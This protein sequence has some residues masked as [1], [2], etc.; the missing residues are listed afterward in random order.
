[1]AS[2]ALR[3]HTDGSLAVPQMRHATSAHPNVD[4]LW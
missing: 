2:V 1:M 3:S 4:W